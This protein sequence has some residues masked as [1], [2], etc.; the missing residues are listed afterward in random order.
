ME[1][2]FKQPSNP[3]RGWIRKESKVIRALLALPFLAAFYFAKL[4]MSL[5]VAEPW[6]ASML[7]KGIVT[8]DTGSAPI[9]NSFYGIKPLDELFVF[10]CSLC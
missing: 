7:E 1:E 10:P 5:T 6:L 3:K 8:W 4:A 2:T 9:R